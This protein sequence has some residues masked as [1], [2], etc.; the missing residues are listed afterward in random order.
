MKNFDHI[1][2]DLETFDNIPT[3]AMSSIGALAFDPYA[4]WING[5]VPDDVPVFYKNVDINSCIKANMSVDGG[6]IQW[7]MEQSDSARKAL[8]DPAPEKL[9]SV[10]WAFSKWVWDQREPKGKDLK[11]GRTTYKP[12]YIWSHGATFDLPILSYAYRQVNKIQPW[13]FV[14]ARDTRTLFHIAFNAKRGSYTDDGTKHNAL[15]DAFTQVMWVQEAYQKLG[16][17]REEKMKDKAA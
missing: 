2:V 9:P 4:D 10:M 11:T 14:N 5:E 12:Y 13:N 6:T 1:M 15:D 16:L 8:F 17:Q 7:W 3:A